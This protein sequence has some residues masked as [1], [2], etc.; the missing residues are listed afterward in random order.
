LSFDLD[1]DGIT[2]APVDVQTSK[3]NH[4]G[5][6]SFYVPTFYLFYPLALE[7]NRSK[8]CPAGNV[9]RRLSFDIIRDVCFMPVSDRLGFH[10]VLHKMQEEQATCHNT[11]SGHLRATRSSDKAGEQQNDS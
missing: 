7:Y 8:L 1:N 10:H 6:A 4:T 3:L 2:K 9:I 11:Q 5:S